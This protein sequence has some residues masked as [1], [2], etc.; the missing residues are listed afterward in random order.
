MDFKKVVEFIPVF[1]FSFMMMTSF[2]NQDTKGIFWMIFAIIGLSGV[3][4]ITNYYYKSSIQQVWSTITM[5]PMFAMYYNTCSLS[6][7]FIAFTFVYLLLPMIY[8]KNI[9]YSVVALFIFFYFADILG[10]QQIFLDAAQKIPNYNGI[11]TFTGT[12]SGITYGILC[13]YLIYSIAGDKFLYFSTTSN[14]NEYCS[15]PKKQQFKC[16]VYKNGQIISSL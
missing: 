11:G 7:F 4:L 16:N 9:N 15:R 13:Y 6:S 10:R 2:I 8:V 3:S 1:I 5:L 12:F 14:N